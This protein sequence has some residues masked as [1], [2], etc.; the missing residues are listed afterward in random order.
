MKVRLK[1]S[2]KTQLQNKPFTI[3][4]VIVPFGETVEVDIDLSKKEDVAFYI[5][6]LFYTGFK[7]G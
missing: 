4:D 6:V 7:I 3:K 1:D 2:V 5:S